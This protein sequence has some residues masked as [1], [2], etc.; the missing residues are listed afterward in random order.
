MTRL[1]N[2]PDLGEA[3]DVARSEVLPGTLYVVATPIGNLGDLSPR[4]QSIL[5]NVDRICAEDTRNTGRL[6]SHFGIHRPLSALH[7][8]N[9][10]R[11][12]AP[13]IEAMRAGA[14]MA[15]VS[16]AGTP[17]I[18]DPGYVLVRAARTAGLPVVAVPGPCA[19]I[20][21]LSISGIAS[22]AFVFAGFLASKSGARR[23]QL[24][25]YAAEPRTL[26]LY[27]SSHRIDASLTDIVEVLGA[28]RRLC[29]AR[30][31]T[32]R[33]ESGLTASASEV[34]AWLREDPNHGRGEFVLIIEGAPAR[35]AGTAEAERTLRVL[36]QA[37]SPSQA[38]RVAAELTGLR[39]SE[40]YQLALQLCDAQE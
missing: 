33:F 16:D 29:L 24:Q 38:S 6:L 9:E 2:Q 21:A 22:D 19:A 20:A 39:K 3:G 37:L 26:I 32:K 14:S 1:I 30:E 31:I 5:S 15:L 40:L 4:A 35:P 11:A 10:D 23:Q 36:L 13:L 8:H 27:E 18:S 7:D 34:L 12:T 17:L 28:D 25:A